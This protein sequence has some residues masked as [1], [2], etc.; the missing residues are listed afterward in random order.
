MAGGRLPLVFGAIVAG[1]VVIDY[2]VR[3]AKGA[4]TSSSSGSGGG[5]VGTA[6][7]PQI[8]GKAP[9]PAGRV[10]WE[11]T[12]Q[13]RDAAGQPGDPITA[14]VSGVVSEI[15]PTFSNG[16]P[17]VVI[18]SPGLPGGASGIYYAEQINPNVQVGQQVQAGE[19]IGTVAPSGTGLEFGFWKNGRTLAQAT[20]GYVEGQVTAA[21]QLF[22]GFL[23]QLGVL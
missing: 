7:A 19:Q 21:G 2:G 3:S 22:D 1:A 15:L 16:Q 20:T 4:L 9:L 10:T 8:S 11:R 6:T 23:H 14:L 12:D 5:A 17:A 13:G 18:S